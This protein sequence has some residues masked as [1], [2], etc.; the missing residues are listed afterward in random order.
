MSGR[1][2]PLPLSFYA[3]ETETVA[4]ALIGVVLRSEIGGHVSTGRIVETEAYVGPHD[5]ASHARKRIGRTPRNASM[6]GPPGRAYI[7]LSYGVHWCL[8]VVTDRDG[9]PGAVLV[10]AVEPLNGHDIMLERRSGRRRDL[11]RGPGRLT[12]AFGITDA[13]DGHLLDRPPLFLHPPLG[14][15]PPELVVGPRVGVSEAKDWPLRFGERDN[16]W[17]SRPF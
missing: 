13:L 5:P 11:T 15:P 14:G 12:Q 10:R 3:R 6:F 4:R 16:R 2:A 7:Y 9:Y 1:P 17:L 8:N